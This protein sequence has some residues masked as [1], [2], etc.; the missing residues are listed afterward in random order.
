M[1]VTIAAV[2]AAIA[3]LSLAG[4]TAAAAQSS[5][6]RGLDKTAPPAQ[7]TGARLQ[8]GLLP[9]SAF[10]PDF[11]VTNTLNTGAKL[12]STRATLQVPTASCSTF[13]GEIYVSG[14]GNTAGAVDFYVNADA[15]TQ[16]P[17]AI[18]DGL[19]DVIQ[20]ATASAAA[21]FFTQAQAKY[22]ACPS[23]SEPNP[24]DTS[25]GGGAFQ[26]STLSVLKTAVSGGDQAFTV[27]QAIAPSETPGQTKYIDV[28]YVVAGTNVY[29]MWQESRTNDEPS[30]A[31]MS[32]LI[33]KIQALYPH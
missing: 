12:E 11:T 17:E 24:T 5:G 25:P 7:V 31:L 10:G 15:S 4:A 30:P 33:R 9:A 2:A 23:F 21:T 26:I 22:A 20:F 13:E 1:K 8:T 19:Q 6:L 32:Q 3:A 16:R 14:F 28:L 27:T 18:I 29:S